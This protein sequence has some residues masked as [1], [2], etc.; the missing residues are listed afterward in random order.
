MARGRGTR[1]QEFRMRV[2]PS[3]PLGST[4]PRHGIYIADGYGIKIRIDHGHLII[5][6]GIGR[7]RRQARFNRATNDLRRLLVTHRIHHP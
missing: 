4:E 7:H 5:D 2:H 6:D 3:E 1:K